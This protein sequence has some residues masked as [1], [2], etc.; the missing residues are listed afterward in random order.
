MWQGQEQVLL[1]DMTKDNLE[2]IDYKEALQQMVVR[3][4]VTILI[5]PPWGYQELQLLSLPL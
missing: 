4:H 3:P 1:L 5:F 2:V